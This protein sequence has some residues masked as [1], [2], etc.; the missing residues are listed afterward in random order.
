MA[1]PGHSSG[2]AGGELALG[3]GA[4][5]DGGLASELRGGLRLRFPCGIE[6]GVDAGVTWRRGDAASFD[7]LAGITWR[8]LWSRLAMRLAAGVGARLD[9]A[10]PAAA[11]RA[12]LRWPLTPRAELSLGLADLRRDGHAPASFL[13]ATLAF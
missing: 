3:L 1:Q 4:G 7:L 8:G 10:M 9:T 2:L 5:L 13:G 12:E 11:W 6:P